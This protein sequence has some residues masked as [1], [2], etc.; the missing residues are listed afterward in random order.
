MN[1]STAPLSPFQIPYFK[2]AK[3]VKREITPFLQNIIYNYTQPLSFE[4]ES[5]TI[6]TIPLIRGHLDTNLF[7]IRYR[8]TTIPTEYPT[9]Q[10]SFPQQGSYSHQIYRRTI[11]PINLL[12]PIKEV[13]QTFLNHVKEH[14]LTNETP[15]FSPNALE[16]LDQH[17]GNFEVEVIER[18]V[19]PQNNPHLWLQADT[20]GIQNFLYHYFKDLTLNNQTIPQVQVISL[21]LRKYFRFNYQL[22]WSPQVQPAFTAFSTY[23]TPDECLPLI[24]SEQNDHPYFFRLDSIIQHNIDRINHD[25][26]LITN[27]NLLDVNRPYHYQRNTPVQQDLLINFDKNDRDNETNNADLLQ[28]QGVNNENIPQQQHENEKY[29]EDN[30]LNENN[31]SEYNTQESTTSAQNASQAGTSTN[32][33]SF[34]IP[35]R[36]VSPRQNTLHPQSNLD[37]FQNR[38]ITF[39]FPPHPDET[40]QNEIQCTIQEDTQHI[41]SIRNTSVNVS[42]PTRTTFINPRYMTRSRYDPPSIP[43]AFQSNRSIQLNDN[44]NDN[45]PTSS[46]YYDPF[47]YSFFPSSDTNTNANNNPN[48]SQPNLNL[49]TQN[50]L[51]NT[52]PLTFSRNEFNSQS[53][54]TSYTT[55]YSH[56]TQPFQRRHQNPPLTHIPADPLYQINQNINHNPSTN[57]LPINTMQPV[58][59]PHTQSVTTP[60]QYIPVQ[61]DTE[62]VCLNTRTYET[63]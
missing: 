40:T 18:L 34:R 53:Q 9:F 39:N 35:T 17:V 43:S 55:S 49:R 46:R 20:L 47:N 25:P 62:Y 11:N 33:Q 36:S 57:Q 22:L 7:C 45:Q 38:N 37:I 14:N 29:N 5:F 6:E 61:H 21:F 19:D 32:T 10:I 58:T 15:K 51:T 54:A 44:H 23:F 59:L 50:P 4:N 30:Q 63:F 60:L 24:I 41:N 16:E 26:H 28:Q 12:T 52:Q 8:N 42:S 56:T 2:N 31:T 1:L 13:F 3:V 27:N 48:F